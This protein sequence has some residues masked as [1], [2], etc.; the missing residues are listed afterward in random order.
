MRKIFKPSL[1]AVGVIAVAW[2]LGG[3]MYFITIT[4]HFRDQEKHDEASKNIASYL[5]GVAKSGIVSER[6][7]KTLGI[8]PTSPR[9]IR[10]PHRRFDFDPNKC[11]Q[12]PQ[13]EPGSRR[14][15]N[16]IQPE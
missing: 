15:I 9:S 1:L 7:A 11:A 13:D 10:D 14:Y 4:K 12:R 8:K 3:M 5:D 16:G 2:W 6:D